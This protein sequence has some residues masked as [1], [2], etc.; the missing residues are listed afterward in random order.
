MPTID[1]YR[2]ELKVDLKQFKTGIAEADKIYTN[3]YAELLAT[4]KK[5][6]SAIAAERAKFG[7][8]F[9]QSTDKAVKTQTD[10]VQK[11]AT[12]QK[13]AQQDVIRETQRAFKG[14]IDAQENL[15]KLQ[16]AESQAS[17]KKRREITVQRI[18]AEIELE[19][20]KFRR[21][22][23]LAKQ[24]IGAAAG[25]AKKQIKLLGKLGDARAASQKRITRFNTQIVNSQKRVNAGSVE[26]AENFATL[27]KSLQA[28]DVA[29]V[30]G[31]L[32]GV[33]AG[34]IGT[35]IDGIKG[36]GGALLEAAEAAKDFED[37]ALKIRTLLSDTQA[38]ALPAALAGL[39]NIAIET[40]AP[41]GVLEESLFNVVSAIPPLANNLQAAAQ[42][43]AKAAK[44]AIALNA[45]TN[46]VTLA[47]TNLGNALG[48]N[49]EQAEAQDR[50]FNTLAQTFKLGVVP[51][52]E[53]MAGAIAKAA[54]L[55]GALTKSSEEALST[56]GAMSAVLTASG[57]TIDE[58]QT[59]IAALSTA[60]LEA[61]NAQKL[62]ALGVEGFDPETGKIESWS[63]V[64]EGMAQNS[65]EVL[66]ILTRKEAKTGFLLLAKEGGKAFSDM[67]AQMKN[68]GG[69]AEDM[70]DIMAQSGKQATARL[71]AAWND[72]MITVGTSVEHM[73]NAG[74]DAL[75]SA[76][77]W[78]GG[79][80]KSAADEFAG[81][82]ARVNE[83][84]GAIGGITSATAAIGASIE[85]GNT[86]AAIDEIKS[87][88]DDVALVDQDVANTLEAIL[89]AP[90]ERTK[91]ELEIINEQLRLTNELAQFE[92]QRQAIDALGSNFAAVTDEVEETLSG[93]SDIEDRVKEGSI[94]Q[95]AAAKVIALTRERAQQQI[96][97]GIARQIELEE[98]AAGARLSQNELIERTTALQEEMSDSLRD[99]TTTTVEGSQ[100]IAGF[101]A[102]F[103]AVAADA[104]A[105]V[106]SVDEA[107]LSL[108]DNTGLAIDSINAKR[109]AETTE[110]AKKAAM[111]ENEIAILNE[112]AELT[113]EQVAKRTELA[114]QLT[115]TVDELQT[116][117][118][119]DEGLL[120]LDEARLSVQEDS[121]AA[122]EE[123]NALATESVGL[124]EDEIK[125][126]EKQG[127]FKKKS[128]QD[129]LNAA[130]ALQA[131]LI[132]MVNVLKARLT[133]VNANTA[134]EKVHGL[135]LLGIAKAQENI[136]KLKAAEATGE[137]V[138]VLTAADITTAATGKSAEQLQK[139]IDALE[140][141]IRV[142][143]ETIGEL[144]AATAKG[145]ENLEEGAEDVEKIHDKGQKNRD[146]D[147]RKLMSDTEKADQKRT[148]A[149]KERAKTEVKGAKEAEDVRAKGFEE[150]RQAEIE[151]VRKLESRR[152]QQKRQA[153]QDLA[154]FREGFRESISGAGSQILAAVQTNIR[155]LD[156]GADIALAGEAAYDEDALKAI[157]SSIGSEINKT[158]ASANEVQAA[159]IKSMLATQGIEWSNSAENLGKQI[160]D[161]W[162]SATNKMFEAVPQ[163]FGNATDA[164]VEAER[165]FSDLMNTVEARAK[166]WVQATG[167]EEEG[168]KLVEKSADFV[169][170]LTAQYKVATAAAVKHYDEVTA[171]INREI[172]A[173]TRRQE[174]ANE[175]ISQQK[176]IATEQ[177]RIIANAQDVIL[178]STATSDEV[179][180]A[181]RAW[182]DALVAQRVAAQS[183]IE[184]QA[185]LGSAAGRLGALAKWQERNNE[186]IANTTK[187][188]RE[189]HDET[190][191]LEKAKQKLGKAAVEAAEGTDDDDAEE[192]I[193]KVLIAFQNL[194]QYIDGDFAQAIEGAAASL[195]D[196]LTAKTTEEKISA[197]L[198]VAEA[199]ASTL[200]NAGEFIDD[201][202]QK[203]EQTG[204]GAAVEAVGDVM[205]KVGKALLNAPPPLNIAG[206]AIL[207]AGVVAK[208]I[209]KIAQAIHGQQKSE[210]D[211]AEDRLAAEQALIDLQNKRLEGMQTLID[212]GD[213]SLD[214]AHEQL[215][216]TKEILAERLRESGLAADLA[217]MS[218][219]ALQTEIERAEVRRS[220]AESSI[221]EAE[222]LLEDGSRRQ[223]R[224]FLEEQG[225]DIK[226]GRTKKAL[227]AFIDQEKAALADAN[228]LLENGNDILDQRLAIL[229]LEKQII[230]EQI[231]VI[232]LR[233]RLEGESVQ[234]LQEIADLARDALKS[235]LETLELDF[236][237]DAFRAAGIASGSIIKGQVGPAL[238]SLTDE[239]L[240]D[241]LLAMT[242]IGDTELSPEIEKL[243]GTWLDAADGVDV[244][245]E[246]LNV[247]GDSADELFAKQKRLL[248]LQRDLGEITE[249]EFEEQMLALLEDRLELLDSIKDTFATEL[250]F[251]L[252]RKDVELE[253]HNLLNKQNQDMQKSDPIMVGLIRRRQQLLDLI[254]QEGGIGAASANRQAELAKIKADIIARM[255]EQGATPAQIQEMIDSLPKFHGGG[256]VTGATVRQSPANR[257][258]GGGQEALIVAKQG[259]FV[260]DANRAQAIG[261]QNMPAALDMLASPEAR[262][263]AAGIMRKDMALLTFN[264]IVNLGGVNVNNN[265]D[266]RGSDPARGG[267][268]MVEQMKDLI[269]R[270]A[271]RAIKAGEISGDLQK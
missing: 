115:D 82:E 180:T 220:D 149:A 164:S 244:Y 127:A 3:F 60:L 44:A 140:D 103:A 95:E 34:L 263:V 68:S 94:T 71:D 132:A 247:A 236:L 166:L 209:G 67:A 154:S 232:R 14:V 248:E 173:E 257:P 202:A 7:K 120:A 214:Q 64:M 182:Q 218:D 156:I 113:D 183:V 168:A 55:M 12:A 129:E 112:Q 155:G 243:A 45:D 171:Q 233:I 121:L 253:I 13:K 147:R 213:R 102:G 38:E 105:G 240:E 57:V 197:T 163:V 54:P 17:G 126:L 225:F 206:A 37:R 108:A 167:D 239:E 21:T 65:D 228:A 259:E 79:F 66:K 159:Q 63:K 87:V 70:F 179:D 264:Q 100:G 176:E 265:N 9:V 131:K 161:M 267:Q 151:E 1:E 104:V 205:T 148:T 24:E 251:A 98:T 198:G 32:G 174:K 22:E 96:N 192:Q 42:V 81:I 75:A 181:T 185:E 193:N 142:T 157:Y 260:V 196:L 110:L 222:S 89:N 153:W 124:S 175:A 25:N 118:G 33:K 237:Q 271:N 101:A 20:R 160:V 130:K 72:A 191:K 266:F 268:Q 23:V 269:V 46:S 135:V 208:I 219:Q 226:R 170:D 190:V 99:M 201:V 217:E 238:D 90:G 31:L 53:A 40:G 256:E 138:K 141:A 215:A 84:A 250:D 6:E 125:L 249:T 211:L 26:M 134:A 189:E 262:Q 162:T 51:S 28:G 86:A 93:I 11:G 48:L 203:V 8:D 107:I 143:G 74:R 234:A 254:R 29:G 77:N 145:A 119:L 221:K 245:T 235:G 80:F 139:E 136:N 261:P 223:R 216:L 109:A 229:E 117:T 85:A 47:T 258:G 178:S 58:S 36:I 212:L 76:I 270:T 122:Q 2:I 242:K 172:A 15:S 116:I 123:S 73:L 10:A 255:T 230:E 241:L 152:Q 18:K 186:Q 246:S 4:T 50:I 184:W 194:G 133:L 30:F 177:D 128:N 169:K 56:I 195:S 188:L 106:S 158:I 92:V 114:K 187:V 204:G 97:D 41:L 224:N 88:L 144:E 210:A 146:R 78:I 52:G 252:A 61:E 43:S 5:G 83:L 91:E 35:A 165:A 16:V 111:L 207:A 59:K 39:R 150:R 231:G 137:E 19:K 69:V 49:L 199:L 62:M 200:M 27:S 227:R